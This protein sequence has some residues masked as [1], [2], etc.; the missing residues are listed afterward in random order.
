MTMK[1]VS[2]D[3]VL[4]GSHGARSLYIPALYSSPFLSRRQT[5]PS[6]LE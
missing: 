3:K 2:N 6:T 5:A 4:A 1:S